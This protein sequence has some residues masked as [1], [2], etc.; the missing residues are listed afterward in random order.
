MRGCWRLWQ[1]DQGCQ[2][3]DQ[4]QPAWASCIPPAFRHEAA[5]TDF[6]PCF[7]WRHGQTYLFS[8]HPDRASAMMHFE[9]HDLG[10]VGVMSFESSSRRRTSACTSPPRLSLI[11]LST[12][13]RAG[14]S[15]GGA[16]RADPYGRRLLFNQRATKRAAEPLVERCELRAVHDGAQPAVA[17][18]T[19]S[20]PEKLPKLVVCDCAR[21]SQGG[22]LASE[23]LVEQEAKEV[24]GAARA[25]GKSDLDRLLLRH[26]D[27][28][29]LHAFSDR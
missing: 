26:L 10:P 22:R 21:A 14:C 7:H 19:R 1:Y 2:G 17:S 4:R 16:P 3:R 28:V 6:T 13:R 20:R 5:R 12:S 8:L 15:R 18:G 9:Q 23:Q 29:C 25:S 11:D 27:S 24:L